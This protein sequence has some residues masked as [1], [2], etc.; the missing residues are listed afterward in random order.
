MS[1]EYPSVEVE[2]SDEDKDL[3]AGVFVIT[4]LRPASQ[5]HYQE[6]VNSGESVKDALFTAIVNDVILA[7]L[8]KEVERIKEQEEDPSDGC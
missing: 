6:L 1:E 5:F 4:N 3:L 2:L 8:E 7:A